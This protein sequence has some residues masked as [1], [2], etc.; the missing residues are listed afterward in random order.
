MTGPHPPPGHPAHP[1]YISPEQSA[2]FDRRNAEVR[3]GLKRREEAER[4]NRP[5]PPFSD[6]EALEALPTAVEALLAKGTPETLTFTTTQTLEGCPYPIRG[7]EAKKERRREKR[8]PIGKFVR[9]V[10]K[11]G[12]FTVC[13][14]KGWELG[15]WH[16]RATRK[17]SDGFED[18]YGV[19]SYLWLLPDGTYLVV[20]AARWMPGAADGRPERWVIP[21]DTQRRPLIRFF[22]EPRTD[23]MHLVA[24]GFILARVLSLT[25]L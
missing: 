11:R 15:A 10:P 7:P 14:A 9:W 21:Y 22:D 20:G 3:A 19:S 8:P 12:E 2:E 17:D 23:D 16:Y 1:G 18:G 6:D 24:P 4:R 5:A 25:P 13:E